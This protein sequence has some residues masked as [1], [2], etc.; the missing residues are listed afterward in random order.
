VLSRYDTLQT[1]FRRILA[2]KRKASRT[3]C[4]SMKQQ[5]MLKASDN[6][7]NALAEQISLTLTYWLSFEVLSHLD[8]RNSVDIGR[9]IYQVMNLV[10]PYLR[11]EERELLQGVSASY[12]A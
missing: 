5:E 1:R 7:I 11:D 6:E 9:G 4:N 3:I 10:A 12:L 8:D 2:N